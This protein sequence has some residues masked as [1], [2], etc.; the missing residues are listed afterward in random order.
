MNRSLNCLT[1]FFYRAIIPRSA[2]LF[3]SITQRGS[4]LFF[5]IY[6]VFIIAAVVG[7]A[8]SGKYTF[9]TI[10]CSRAWVEFLLALL[11]FFNRFRNLLQRLPAPILKPFR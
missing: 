3:A 1:H 6:R 8:I 10:T 5:I 11:R 7:F 9:A 4:P 2:L